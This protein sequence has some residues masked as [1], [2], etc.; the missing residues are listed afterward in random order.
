MGSTGELPPLYVY[1][2]AILIASLEILN[3]SWMH[4]Y[5]RNIHIHGIFTFFIAQVIAFQVNTTITVVN[6]TATITITPSINQSVELQCA[7]S[8]FKQ[9]YTTGSV[10]ASTPNEIYT[11]PGIT[12][13]LA[14]S[15]FTT[16]HA[17][18]YTCLA[19]TSGDTQ[20]KTTY[21]VVLGES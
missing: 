11:K 10:I 20:T 21:P 9:W 3:L 6:V 7:N 19:S 13:I 5:R 17:G 15:S 1:T 14:F 2:I 16:S 8:G 12:R 18:T 4:L